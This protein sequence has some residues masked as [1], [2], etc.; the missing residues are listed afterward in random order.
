MFLIRPV[1]LSDMQDFIDL[2]LPIHSGISS[3]PKNIEK[4]KE[5]VEKSV[6]AISEERWA[7]I[8]ELYLFVLEEL[9]TKQLAGIC[10]IYSKSRTNVPVPYYEIK[11]EIRFCGTIELEPQLLLVPGIYSKKPSEM[12]SLFLHRNFRKEGL[13][14]LLS[15]S[16]LLFIASNRQRFDDW[17]IANLRGIFKQ[18]GQCLFWEEIGRRF[19]NVDYEVFLNMILN[20]P[21]LASGLLPNYPLYLTLLSQELQERAGTP[22]PNSIPAY[23]MLLNQGF[24]FLRKIDPFDGGPFVEAL[25][26]QISLIKESKTARITSIVEE[27]ATD[28][29]VIVCNNSINFRAVQTFI[30]SN[31]NGEVS[32]S[33][34]IA[35]ALEVGIGDTIRYSPL[36]RSSHE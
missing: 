2:A 33:K 6:Q 5:N 12:C 18:N 4:L 10:G 29:A 3:F 17:I 16:R 21:A 26:D 23:K 34:T 28:T 14:K 8:Q 31:S 1:A 19:L 32:L 13:G 30:T 7:P 25:V 36:V 35:Q 20:E 15:L 27:A 11:K 24:Q 22:H 9:E